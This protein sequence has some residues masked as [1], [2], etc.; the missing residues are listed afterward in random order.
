MDCHLTP[1]GRWV[2]PATAIV[3]CDDDIDELRPGGECV[4][5]R[6][7]S[8]RSVPLQVEFWL[9]KLGRKLLQRGSFTS[10]DDLLPRGLA[11]IAYSNHTTTKP[12]RWTY[13]GKVLIA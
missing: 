3:A 7:R 13:Q 1:V 11:F 6:V 8:Y 12:F 9:G 5:T 2:L 4:S 10:T